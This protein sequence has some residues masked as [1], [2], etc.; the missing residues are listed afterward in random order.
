MS[1]RLQV[2]VDE[3]ELREVKRVARAEKTTVS[4]WVR[5]AMRAALRR[6]PTGDAKRKLEVI[7]AAM[8]YDFPAPDVEQMNAEITRGYLW[9]PEP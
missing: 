8:E 2:L 5:Q 9:T 4:A 6:R 7:R 3:R 1:K